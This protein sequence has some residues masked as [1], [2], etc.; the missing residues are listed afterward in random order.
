MNQAPPRLYNCSFIFNLSVI[1][2]HRGW[3][4]TTTKTEAAVPDAGREPDA[5]RA[6]GA[7]AIAVPSAPTN[8][9]N[10]H[11]LTF[12]LITKDGEKQQREPTP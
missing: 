8:P 7:P 10:F 5:T 2:F 1:N 6:T 4:K 9:F 12:L 11:Y 3:G